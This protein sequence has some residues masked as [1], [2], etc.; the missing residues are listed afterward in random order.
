MHL[1]QYVWEAKEL[2]Q[3]CQIMTRVYAK[4]KKASYP[5]QENRR[6]SR[7]DCDRILPVALRIKK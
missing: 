3:R 7:H 1:G 4:K 6:V 2:V 5:K